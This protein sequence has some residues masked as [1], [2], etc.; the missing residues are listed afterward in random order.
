MKLPLRINFIEASNLFVVAK[1]I[2]LITR[3]APT[4]DAFL[5]LLEGDQDFQTLASLAQATVFSPS[6]NST[7]DICLPSAQICTSLTPMN[8]LYYTAAKACVW[9]SVQCPKESD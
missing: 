4:D 1:F 6:L 7:M 2:C 9:Q 3:A 8:S 5:G